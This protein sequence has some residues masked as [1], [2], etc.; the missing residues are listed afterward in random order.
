MSD[1]GFL[2]RLRGKRVE[3]VP[4]RRRNL[5]TATVFQVAKLVTDRYE[6]LC[7][8]RDVSSS[9]LK[10]EAYCPLAIGERIEIELKTEHQ[11]AG[12][13]AWIRDDMFGMQ[14][15]ADVPVLAMLAHCAFD[16]RIARIRP[17][18]LSSSLPGT[19]SID[20]QQQPVTML[21]VSLAGMK[22]AL[23]KIV[24]ADAR[25]IATL[26]ELGRRSCTV[27]WVRGGEAG[28]MFDEPLAYLDFVAW[29]RR[30]LRS[31]LSDA[32]T[33]PPAS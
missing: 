16:D 20:E 1:E 18:R 21:N 22:I 11:V 7:L 32:A 8:L 27:R 29:R 23:E 13:V 19:I 31:A 15:D 10:A 17:P 6:E 30:L 14:F 25:T 28:V 33:S 9:G 12:E 26:P 5:R 4:E 3:E 24:P 2:K